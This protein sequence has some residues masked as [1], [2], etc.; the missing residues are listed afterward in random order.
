MF[1]SIETFRLQLL[2][3]LS[4]RV[5]HSLWTSSATPAYLRKV[6]WFR[7]LSFSEVGLLKCLQHS[8]K[9]RQDFITS[10]FVADKISL[11]LNS[12]LGVKRK[13]P[14]DYSNTSFV[15][16]PFV[17]V[18]SKKK[19]DNVRV[20]KASKSCRNLDARLTLCAGNYFFNFLVNR[21]S[22][23]NREGSRKKL[24]LFT[25]LLQIH[26]DMVIFGLSS[27]SCI[28]QTNVFDL[29]WLAFYHWL[30]HF[31]FQL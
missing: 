10:N 27:V 6:H 8:V 12:L 1:E 18:Q 14:K 2:F 5:Q 11:F 30:Q 25:L 29:P 31:Q 19:N 3:F 21:I 28:R 22:N 4:F 16:H 20:Y 26:L 17:L 23:R 13:T 7:T 15:Q 9:R 24:I